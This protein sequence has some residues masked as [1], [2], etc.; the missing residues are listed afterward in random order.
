MALVGDLSP[1]TDFGN[2]HTYLS[3]A[4]PETPS[5]WEDELAAAA[6]NSGTTWS[7]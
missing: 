4:M 6:R 3:G 2:T 1:W 5:I 7:R